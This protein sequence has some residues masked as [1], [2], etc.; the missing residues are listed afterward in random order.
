M[1]DEEREWGEYMDGFRASAG[2]AQ[3]G[4]S[5]MRTENSL[6]AEGYRFGLR[7][8]AQARARGKLVVAGEPIDDSQFV[9]RTCRGVEEM[10][11]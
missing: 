11:R 7:A 10:Q 2:S 8:R 3:A 5:D 6:F 9:C 4:N 1:D